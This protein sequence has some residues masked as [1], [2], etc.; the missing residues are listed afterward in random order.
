MFPTQSGH[1]FS[2]ACPAVMESVDCWPL[3]TISSQDTRGKVTFGNRLQGRDRSVA[4]LPFTL[5]ATVGPPRLCRAGADPQRTKCRRNSDEATGCDPFHLPPQRDGV[6][7]FAPVAGIHVNTG[8][9]QNF[10]PDAAGAFH[11]CRSMGCP[12][13]SF[14]R[15]EDSYLVDPASSHMLVSKIKPCMSKYKQSIQ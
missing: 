10:H 4:S 7:G 1:T 3:A 5:Y 12:I 9:T 13:H 8:N 11:R 15:C 14:G 6:L 2:G